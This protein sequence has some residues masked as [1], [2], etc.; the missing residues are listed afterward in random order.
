MDLGK[1]ISL[2][3]P[4]DRQQGVASNASPWCLRARLTCTHRQLWATL[5]IGND[6]ELLSNIFNA[7]DSLANPLL[8]LVA[9]LQWTLAFQAVPMS[10]SSQGAANGGN[11]LGLSPSDGNLFIVNLGIQWTDEADDARL[12]VAAEEFLSQATQLANTKGLLN[13]FV[14]LNYALPTQNPLGSYGSENL[15][16]LREVSR[17]YDPGQVFQR[18][19][20]GG[21]KI[22]N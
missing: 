9:N 8:S 18:L 7:S 12:N 19:V 13:D 6:A 16:K 22:P 10:A 1:L 21:F 20:P 14:Y 17:K 11:V 4:Y 2:L 5:T 15:Q 3:N